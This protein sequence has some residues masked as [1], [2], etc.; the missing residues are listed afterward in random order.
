MQANARSV[1]NHCQPLAL[2][3]LA[4]NA[5][6]TFPLTVC[7]PIVLTKALL[8]GTVEELHWPEASEGAKNKQQ[9]RGPLFCFPSP[10]IFITSSCA[11]VLDC[12]TV[13]YTFHPAILSDQCRND[14]FPVATKFRFLFLPL[15][16]YFGI[17]QCEIRA[18]H[19]SIWLQSNTASLPA[20]SLH[21]TYWPPQ[22]TRSE[23][24]AVVKYIAV[25]ALPMPFSASRL[26]VTTAVHE[27]AKTSHKREAPKYFFN[28]LHSTGS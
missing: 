26:P 28:Q 21:W 6:R 14:T 27:Q 25:V 23:W 22:C 16:F 1:R 4:H 20:G 5:G 3:L 8:H 13:A 24:L 17:A 15:T 9:R 18:Q 10:C 19:G 11:A 2:P 7:P 12:T